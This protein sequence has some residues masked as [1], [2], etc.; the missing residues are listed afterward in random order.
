[1]GDLTP[2][3]RQRLARRQSV[4][5][6]LI[7]GKINVDGR[8]DEPDWRRAFP[9]EAFFVYQAG[10]VAR[11][12]TRV[13]ALRDA[14]TLYV[15]ATC[16][17][18]GKAA[19]HSQARKPGEH[20]L[21]DESFELFV[22]PPDQ[23][24]AYY[25]IMINAS[26]SVAQK[27]I[28]FKPN[29]AGGRLRVVDRGWRAGNMA[30]RTSPGKG[31]WQ[32]EIALPI[33]DVG[34]RVWNSRWR[35]NLCRNFRGGKG[36]TEL[37]S[38][39]P[40]SA[41]DFHDLS[42]YPSLCLG[43]G[44]APAPQASLDVSGFTTAVRTLPDRI[45]TVCQFRIEAFSDRILHNVR[46]V[47][48]CF[49]A[50]G[51]LHRRKVIASPERVLFR[52]SPKEIF[53]IAF[54]QAVPSGGVRLTL[55]S[56]EARVERWVRVGGWP[57]AKGMGRTLGAKGGFLQGEAYFASEVKAAG[58]AQPVKVMGKLRGTVEFRFKPNWQDRAPSLDRLRPWYPVRTLFH[59]G[60]IRKNH[61]FL[62][63]CSSVVIAQSARRDVLGFV[64]S[65]SNYAG[66]QVSTPFK[67]TDSWR[68]V[69][70]VWDLTA[71]PKDKLRLYLDGKRVADRTHVRKPE[72]LKGKS[73][74][75]NNGPFVIQ[76]GSL[77]S[78]RSAAT[79]LIDD[80][81]ISRTARY[82]TDFDPKAKPASPDAD[83][84]ALFR[85]DGALE[86]QGVAPDGKRYRLSAAPGHTELW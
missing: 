47:G 37:S 6:P 19:V 73:A 55:E 20:V 51:R 60:L 83:T 58:Q 4:H 65:T 10:T 50:S 24:G 17:M 31:L 85:F 14:K 75:V 78:G 62:S 1:M 54:E 44:R 82:T 74:S 21:Q 11:G 33:A 22:A 64:I 71:P 79:A 27:R 45:A 2:G 72:R 67:A 42:K 41:K 23:K 8:L 81:R 53:S 66:W 12:D 5:A 32:V 68:H 9:A 34:A 56:D 46:I 30:V 28:S 69:A 7:S 57:G 59:F 61:P 49:D 18:P 26:G 3:I 80:L 70:C 76:L 13:R 84:T 43:P 52:W 48:E 39:L 29:P 16:R 35:V 15:G 25:H 86:G 63:N 77:N 36:I 38:I 40:P